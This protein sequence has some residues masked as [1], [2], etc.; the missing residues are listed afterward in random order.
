M[1]TSKY[2]SKLEAQIASHLSRG[3]VQFGYES[4][5]FPYVKE[6]RYT[7]DF[8]LPTGVI[9][10]AKGWFRPEDRSK[11]LA[12]KANNPGLDLRLVFQNA[13]N[14]LNK[15]SKTTY[16]EWATKHGFPFSDGGRIPAD[17]IKEGTQVEIQGLRR[18]SSKVRK[19]VWDKAEKGGAPVT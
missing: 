9:L 6:C 15:K 19:A 1:P 3:G 7:P 17:W 14:R 12:V 2:R 10:E 16:G 5:S 18:V 8:I 11:L 4:M 13:R